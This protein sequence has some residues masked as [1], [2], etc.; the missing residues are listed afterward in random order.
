M[1]K[2]LL[3]ALCLI[4]ANPHAYA[5]VASATLLGEVHD[6]SGALAPAVTVTVRQNATGFLR[7]SATNAQ[8]A[9]RIDELIP[10]H[11][12]VRPKDRQKVVDS[13]AAIPSS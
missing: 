13:Q 4:A 6:E 10:G 9:Y 5:Q 1:T 11:Y 7:T 8:G 3:I 12:S 2:R